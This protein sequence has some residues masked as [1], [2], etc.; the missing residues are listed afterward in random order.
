MSVTCRFPYA[1]LQ[2]LQNDVE[3]L[4][5]TVRALQTQTDNEDAL[6]H[7]LRNTVESMG[8]VLSSTETDT[9]NV[10]LHPT[11]TDCTV[12]T[13][14]YLDDFGTPHDLEETLD[15]KLTVES[16]VTPAYYA[17]NRKIT[18]A[19]DSS[20][21][22][23]VCFC[24][25]DANTSNTTYDCKILS[26]GGV[27]GVEGKGDLTVYSNRTFFSG[28]VDVSK[29]NVTCKTLTLNGNDLTSTY[30]TKS[31]SDG[32]YY[33]KTNSDDRYYTKSQSDSNYYTKTQSDSNYAG[34]VSTEASLTGLEGEIAALGDTLVDLG[35]V[36][37]G[38]GGFSLFSSVAL[39]GGVSAEF[40]RCMKLSGEQ[41]LSGSIMFT[42]NNH[43]FSGASPTEISYLST[44]SSNIQTQLNTKAPLAS[45]AFTGTATLD[46]KTLA[47][48]DIV[49]GYVTS[50]SLTTTLLD[51]ATQSW[52]STNLIY[53]TPIYN[54]LSLAF[55]R[56]APK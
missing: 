43:K 56:L 48:T 13:L 24:S 50:S 31:A 55:Q 47:T 52:V 12:G 7:T 10:F 29:N 14:S 32:R 19:C 49:T 26:Q 51:N 4:S 22:A 33:T 38:V 9:D 44:V 8:S 37:G 2:Q 3:S 6:L 46:G 25:N 34:R 54:P 45:P 42:T 20:N 17:N 21:T 27:A 28:D 40:S 16:R 41:T 18:L 15:T 23:C 5:R 1:L 30:Y 36:T 53:C 35:L 11:F 39:G